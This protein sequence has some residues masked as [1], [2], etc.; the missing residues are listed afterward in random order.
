MLPT[1]AELI[2]LRKIITWA[3]VIFIVFYL[4]TQ[5]SGAAHVISNLLN[6]LKSAGNSLATFVNSL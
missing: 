6:L 4:L 5:P 1:T 2:M 3:I